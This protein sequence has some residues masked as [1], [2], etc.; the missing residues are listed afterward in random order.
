MWIPTFRIHGDELFDCAD[1]QPR[2]AFVGIWTR[3]KSRAR[4]TSDT[5]LFRQFRRDSSRVS[6]CIMRRFASRVVSSSF[7]RAQE[8][9]IPTRLETVD[10]VERAVNLQ[11]RIREILPGAPFV[12]AL[13]KCDL[14]KWQVTEADLAAL[15]A[16]G[17]VFQTS[18]WNGEKVNE[19]FLEVANRLSQSAEEEAPFDYKRHAEEDEE[20]EEKDTPQPELRFHL[21][22]PRR[23]IYSKQKGRWKFGLERRRRPGSLSISRRI[24]RRS[25][26]I[27]EF[28][29]VIRR[30]ALPAG[31]FSGI[32]SELTRSSRYRRI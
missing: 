6:T 12:V 24:P 1:L 26:P 20:K 7:D 14:P 8:L 10:R 32:L 21:M 3:L 2:C 15:N 11:S 13:N 23:I 30:S 18:T 28:V 5:T 4:A 29:A 17:T 16:T 9:L 25:F 19:M 31:W 27:R 22:R